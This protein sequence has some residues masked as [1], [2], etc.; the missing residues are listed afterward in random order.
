MKP[1]SVKATPAEKR[2]D[3][4]QEEGLLGFEFRFPPGR[5]PDRYRLNLEPAQFAERQQAWVCWFPFAHPCTKVTVM[6]QS[7]PSKRKV[8]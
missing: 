7:Q 3:Q 6:R 1:D 2:F 5:G 4:A 8:A